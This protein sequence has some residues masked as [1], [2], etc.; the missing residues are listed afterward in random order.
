MHRKFYGLSV[1]LQVHTWGANL[2]HNSIKRTVNHEY[3]QQWVNTATVQIGYLEC[4]LV[5]FPMV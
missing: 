5:Y 2:Q 1:S 3:P 4:V